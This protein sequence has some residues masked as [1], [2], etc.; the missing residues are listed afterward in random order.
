LSTQ[1]R[2]LAGQTLL[3]GL[4][5]VVP[6]FLNW[7]LVWVYTRSFLP[8]EYGIVTE[9]Y[10]YITFLLVFLTMGLE[11]AFFKFSTEEN[12]EKDK[13]FTNSFSFVFILSVVFYGIVFFYRQNITSFFGYG[14]QEYFLIMAGVVA[15]DAIS[16]IPFAKLRLDERPLKFSFV[17][18]INVIINIGLNI[19]FIVICP[20]LIEKGYNGFLLKIYDE[21]IG[22][23]YI[24]I[25]NLV[26]VIVQFIL[27][28]PEIL[29]NKFKPDKNIL[30]KLL[31]YGFPLMIAGL[32]GISNESLDRI[33]LKHLIVEQPLYYLGIYGANI[34]ISVLMMLF[35]QMFRYAFEPFFFKNEKEKDSKLLY[36]DVAK[37]FLFFSLIAFLSI[38]F[39]LDIIKYF[40]DYKYWEGLSIIPYIC[41]G[42]V[43]YGMFVNLSVWYK[44]TSKTRY[45]AWLT[46]VGAM[47]TVLFNVIFVP[48]MGYTAAAIARVASYGTMMILSFFVGRRFYKVPYQTGKMTIYFIFAI[49][50]YFLSCILRNE[51]IYV[52]ILINSGLLIIFMT[53]LQVK[54]KF[55]TTI[56][57]K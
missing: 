41:I 40:I 5:T 52:N 11:T 54:E 39:Y 2:K 25:S 56:L 46:F 1:I 37:Y 44:V 30:Y 33:L 55:F 28:S 12:I 22:I 17:K 48:K 9:I 26:A 47:I 57:K 42:Y 51:K 49:G 15:L 24:F 32:A 29:K 18:I 35:I 13:V 50:L 7:L 3:Y 23:G 27:L 16:A 53:V 19:F 36:A 6:R 34:K 4:S 20:L 31:L 45:G 38:V 10:G 21:N 14:H 8:E 43:F